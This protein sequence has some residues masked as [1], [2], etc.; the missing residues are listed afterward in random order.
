VLHPVTMPMVQRRKPGRIV[1]LASVSGLVGNRGQ[2]NYSAAKAGIIGA[3]KA[4]AIELA[5]RNITVNCV[6]PGLI[7][8]EML[9]KKCSRSAEDDSHAARWA[10]GG[11]GGMVAFLLG[12]RGGVHHAPG[13]LGQR[14]HGL[15]KRRG[16][17]RRGR[18]QPAGPRLAHGASAALRGL[19]NAVQYI[20][21]WDEIEGL[22]TRLG[23]PAKP[24]TL[25]ALQPQG[26]AQHGPRRADGTRATELALADAGLLG[27]PLVRSGLA[28]A[29][30]TAPR[31]ARRRPSPTS[32]A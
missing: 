14:G 23:V 8:T 3:T 21:G 10:A 27:D 16:R 31:S 29:S 12:D 26:H 24:S 9:P 20:P 30:P 28:W 22:N 5:K 6:A 13:D 4:L 7:E 19:R 17:H 2:T 11:G 1:T 18:H 15:M 25:P 32:A